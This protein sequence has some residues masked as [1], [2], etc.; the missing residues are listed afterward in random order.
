L[1]GVEAL[2]RWRHPELGLIDPAVFIPIAERTGKIIELGEFVLRR[3]LADL[4]ALE[5]S[6][7]TLAVNVSARQLVGGRLPHTVAAALADSGVDPGR[8]ILEIT[9]SAFVDDPEAARTV[10]ADLHEIGVLI[11]LDDFGTGWSSMQYLRTL[12]VDIL[13]VDRTFVTDLATTLESPAVVSAVLNLGHGLGLVV[14]AEGVEDE[15]TLAVLREMGCDEYQGFID[16][17]PGPLGD[18]ILR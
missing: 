10:L 4:A 16:G 13:K 17:I 18:V 3:A 7:L 15:D 14:V 11:A 9:E 5:N 2:L 1:A 12:P 6:R 8:L